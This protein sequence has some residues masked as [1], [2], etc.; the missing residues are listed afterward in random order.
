MKGGIEGSRWSTVGISGG[1]REKEPGPQ[2]AE[3][4]AV[5]LS[6]VETS[7]LNESGQRKVEINKQAGQAGRNLPSYVKEKLTHGGGCG[8]GDGGGP[9]DRILRKC[10]TP[11]GLKAFSPKMAEAVISWVYNI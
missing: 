8:G 10:F 9:S 6:C 1:S 2:E 5:L 11:L 3:E 4:A 7:L